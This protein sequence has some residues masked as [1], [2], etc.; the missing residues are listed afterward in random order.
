MNL[1]DID[2]IIFDLGGVIL[3]LDY[4]LTVKAFEQIIPAI[5]KDSFFGKKNQ[6]SFFNDYEVGRTST[7]EFINAFNNHYRLNLSQYEFESMWNAMILDL[8]K[9]RIDLIN[10]L[11]SRGKKIYLLSNI[12][13]LHETAVQGRYSEIVRG[14]NFLEEFDKAYYSHHIGLRKPNREIFD[15]V[16]QQHNLLP[17]K[18]LFIDD[19]PHHVEGAK[20]AGINSVHLENKLPLESLEFLYA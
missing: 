4:N 13:D 2:A 12:N 15:F 3:N 7:A 9:E 5:D 1:R 18:T 17:E 11:R 20:S 6:L 8:P 14:K 10:N 16:L 19:S